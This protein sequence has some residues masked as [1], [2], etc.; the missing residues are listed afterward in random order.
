VNG[1]NDPVNNADERKETGDEPE[2]ESL[3]HALSVQRIKEGNQG[4]PGQRFEIIFGERKD[5]KDGGKKTEEEISFFHE[6]ILRNPGPVFKEIRIIGLTVH[7][8]EV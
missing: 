5:E 2:H 8:S 6:S 7:I 3:E 1:E 4:K